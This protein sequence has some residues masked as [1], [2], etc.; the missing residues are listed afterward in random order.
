MTRGVINIS[1]VPRA[2][3]Q[4]VSYLKINKM[5]LLLTKKKKKTYLLKLF[6]GIFCMIKV[7]LTIILKNIF[8]LKSIFFLNNSYLVKFKNNF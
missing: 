4:Q 2:H 1:M 8:N 3:K 6:V 5:T 7:Y